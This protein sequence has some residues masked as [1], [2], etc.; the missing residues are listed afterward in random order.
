MPI[1]TPKVD[2]AEHAAHAQRHGSDHEL[3]IVTTIQRTISATIS[4]M[5]C[6]ACHWTSLSSFST[7]NGTSARSQR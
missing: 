7:S 5:P 3:R 1:Q 4:T 6:L 2:E